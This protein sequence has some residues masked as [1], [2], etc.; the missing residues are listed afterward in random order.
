MNTHGTNSKSVLTV[1]ALATWAAAFWVGTQQSGE[2]A[3]TTDESQPATQTADSSAANTAL[4]EVSL[5]Q[6]NAASRTLE[7]LRYLNAC[8]TPEHFKSAIEY[9]EGSADKSEKNRYLA[10]AFAAWLRKDPQAALASVRR[11]ESLRHSSGQVAESFYNWG[12]QGPDA[13]AALLATTLDG[14][15]SDPST[16][17]I[18]LDGIDPPIFLLSLVAGLSQTDPLLAANTLSQAT[19]SYVRTD[20]IEVLYQ[21]WHPADPTTSQN[22]A[23]EVADADTRKLALSTAATKAGQLDQ[24]ESGLN[25]AMNLSDLEDR[26]V[27]LSAL[28]DQ[29]SQRRSVEAFQ[30]TSQLEEEDLK[31]SL[32]PNVLENFA[33]LNP[34]AA[35]DWL[36]QYEASPQMDA[37]IAAYA[38][39]IQH[40]NPQAALGSA[41]AITDPALRK[42]VIEKIEAAELKNAK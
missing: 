3:V 24:T 5:D 10:E 29:W 16:K 7:M 21:S 30:W 32:M 8:E 36:N 4:L 40:V 25:W 39:A 6:K 13:A 2:T 15:Q 38:K 35:A 20:A 31:L 26:K 41:E 28:T 9:I 34:G 11:V 14:S 33:R 37:S 23:A 19:D 1:V 42:S 17:P 22:W 27:A 12:A 18:F